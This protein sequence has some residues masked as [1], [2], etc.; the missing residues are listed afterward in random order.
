MS[1][2]HPAYKPCRVCGEIKHRQLEFHK[3]PGAKDGHKSI[4][5]PCDAIEG[6]RYRMQLP[7]EE[8]ER[9]A[10]AQRRYHRRKSVRQYR[11]W[12]HKLY[13]Q[14]NAELVREALRKYRCNNREKVREWNRQYY[15]RR[16]ARPPAA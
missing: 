4:C 8:V 16:K 15:Y 5:T 12:S 11:N 9:R 7:P 2:V 6:K 14:A 3:A 10:K 13:K 1:N